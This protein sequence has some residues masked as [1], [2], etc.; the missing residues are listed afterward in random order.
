MLFLIIFF[1]ALHSRVLESTN[2][3]KSVKN[4]ESCDDWAREGEC[5]NNPGYLWL[6]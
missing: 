2:L 1:V 5:L 6:V 3:F 4:N